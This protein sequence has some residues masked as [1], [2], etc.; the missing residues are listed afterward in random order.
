MKK[1]LR[2]NENKPQT[3]EVCLKD[4][5]CSDTLQIMTSTYNKGAMSYVF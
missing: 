5:L 3:P 4:F 2:C 1:F